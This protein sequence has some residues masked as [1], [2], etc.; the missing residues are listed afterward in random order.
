MKPKT[1]MILGLGAAALMLGA[2][3]A[4]AAQPGAEWSGVYAGALT[5]AQWTSSH[6]S[7]PGDTAD[8]LL[9][10]H[11]SK[12]SWSGGGLIGFNYQT[13]N[14]VLGLEGDIAGG[15]NK[16]Q[17]TAC[18][19]PDGCWTPAHDSF[20]TFNR[21]KEGWNGHLR[22]RM[23]WVSGQNLFYVAG[24]YSAART[25]LDLVGNCY[26]PGNP[27]VPLLFNFSR[28]KTV[29][30]F[31]LGAGVERRIGPHLSV[32]AEYIYDGFGHQLYRG[33]G[34]EWNDRRINLHNSD[35]RVAISYRF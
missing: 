25:R 32:R 34:S 6:F 12:T 33:D 15:D 30:G 24:G 3:R 5:G 35:L 9:S 20:T 2:S 29:S 14:M 16:Q 13:G 1:S 18:T 8:A 31:N 22:A 10:N 23:G 19:V 27:S 4:H 7:L 28:S 21:L 26:N 11:A 17:V